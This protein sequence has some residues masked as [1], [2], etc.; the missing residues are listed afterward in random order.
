[1]NVFGVI[2]IGIGCPL[3]LSGAVLLIINDDEGPPSAG[4]WFDILLFGGL[5]SLL[6]GFAKG[7][8]AAINDR[9]CPSFTALLIFL[10]GSGMVASGIPLAG[11]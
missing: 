3:L 10:L 6:R 8:A 1:M 7:L 5:L 2:L 11:F 4:T 9:T